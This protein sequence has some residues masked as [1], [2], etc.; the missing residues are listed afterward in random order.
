[1]DK[2]SKVNRKEAQTIICEKF[3][4]PPFSFGDVWGLVN[5]IF[6]ELEEME[7]NTAALQATIQE[8]EKQLNKYADMLHETVKPKTCDGCRY[9]SDRNYR[10]Y[11]YSNCSREHTRS[12]K[13]DHYEPKACDE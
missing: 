2:G 1:M 3:G 9:D 4:S 10:C 13:I 5:R 12:E 6:D 7:C 11:R 8:Q